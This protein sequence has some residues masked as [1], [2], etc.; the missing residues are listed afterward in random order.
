V[1]C[2][3]GRLRLLLR[4]IKKIVLQGEANWKGNCMFTKSTYKASAALAVVFT[5]HALA[6]SPPTTTVPSVVLAALECASVP[7]AF[8]TGGSGGGGVQVLSV[9]P[10]PN[11]YGAVNTVAFT[12]S[13]GATRY[14]SKFDVLVSDLTVFQSSGA[15]ALGT[16]LTLVLS[17]KDIG[18]TLTSTTNIDSYAVHENNFVLNYPITV[19]PESTVSRGQIVLSS[20]YSMWTLV[21]QSR[22]SQ[23]FRNMHVCKI[24]VN[25]PPL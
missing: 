11:I 13:T 6:I 5:Q 21:I 7:S 22:D 18:S 19:K 14:R 25:V 24:P 16:D 15:I 9:P 2:L 4:N 1:R 8:I 10:S 12:T 23:S 3:V 17:P 20:N